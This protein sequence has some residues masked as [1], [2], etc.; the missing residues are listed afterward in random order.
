MGM[1][2]VD[3]VSKSKY[4]ADKLGKR[5]IPGPEVDLSD[6]K[7]AEA[8]VEDMVLGEYHI[9]G[10][11]A[12]G[13]AL[14]SHLRVKGAECLRVID[15]SAFPN[16]VSGNICSSV[17]ALAEKGADILKRDNGH[18]ILDKLAQLSVSA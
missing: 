5:V 15:A 17:Y 12:M 2:M 13:D 6:L 18:A 7:Q 4:L 16:N 8:L 9:C 11:V 1:A 10:S 14:D 3:K